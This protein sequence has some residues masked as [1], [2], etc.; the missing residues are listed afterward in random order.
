MLSG[1]TCCVMQLCMACAAAYPW[2][3]PLSALTVLLFKFGMA[4]RRL[5]WT[6]ASTER[7][8]PAAASVSYPR[9]HF[10][11]G[12]ELKTQQPYLPS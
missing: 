6:S 2:C 1:N 10:H 3:Q 7:D 12:I 4:C 9:Y 5:M 8:H 11:A